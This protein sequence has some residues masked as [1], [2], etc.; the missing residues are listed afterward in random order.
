MIFDAVF[1]KNETI[2]NSIV[3]LENILKPLADAVASQNQKDHW[4]MTPYAQGG[5]QLAAK[6]EQW[7]DGQNGMFRG[8]ILADSQM[9]ETKACREVLVRRAGV[10]VVGVR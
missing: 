4:Q 8:V 9:A 3:R 7:I 10:V 1:A 6:L 2:T 5:P